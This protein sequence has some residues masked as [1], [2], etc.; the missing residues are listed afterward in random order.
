MDLLKGY[1]RYKVSKKLE[2]PDEILRI[3]LLFYLILEHW[4]ENRMGKCMRITNEEKTICEYTTSKLK[5]G[6]YLYQT[7]FARMLCKE[8]ASLEN[9][10]GM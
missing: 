2:I 7:I 10:N 4:D 1:I 9:R 8:S 6:T 5:H 3:C